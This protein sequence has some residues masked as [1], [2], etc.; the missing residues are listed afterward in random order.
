L[1]F[2]A[3]ARK[4]VV[5]QAPAFDAIAAG[6]V[7]LGRRAH[8]RGWALGTSGN[9]SAVV[10]QDPLRLA[11]TASGIDKARLG[12]DQILEVDAKG[13]PAGG[14]RR[15]SA[16]TPIHLAI[17]RARGAGA[18]AHT[19]S[20]WS[21]LLSEAHAEA[22][23]LALEG[24]EMLKG[25]AGVSTHAHREWLTIVE[26]TQDWDVGARRLEAWLRV[27]AAAHGFLIQRHGLYTW[28]RDLEEAGR[29]LEVLEF[30]LEAVGRGGAAG[31]AGAGG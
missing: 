6:L 27:D 17:V 29:H 11:I 20:L 18:V 5:P 22:G 12:T 1:L 2:G 14:V 19:H 26:N 21:T 30:L 28:G 9:F 23:G 31:G 13:A 15:P 8:A 3:G 24:Y 25:L 10:S 16:E 4:W 7:E